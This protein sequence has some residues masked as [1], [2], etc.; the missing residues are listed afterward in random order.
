MPVV[1][2]P[3]VLIHD[4]PFDP[5][6]GY[7][8]PDLL[9]VG[10]PAPE[11]AGFD[12]YWQDRY[13][14]AIAL[15]P[16]FEITETKP[17][18][19]YRRTFLVRIATDGHPELSG[20]IDIPADQPI[21]AGLVMLHG[22]GGRP[23]GP[24]QAVF[25]ENCAV[26]SPGL[27]GLAPSLIDGLSADAMKHVLTGIEDRNTYVL[28]GCIEDVWFATTTLL[29][30]F[31]ECAANLNLIGCS[32][33]GGIGLLALAFDP[34]FR[35]AHFS[36]PTFGNH[37]L[38]ATLPCLGSGEAIRLRYQTDPGILDTLAYFDSAT[39][40]K[41]VRIPVSASPA[42]FD[43]AVPPPGQFAA[44]NALAGPTT[45]FVKKAGHFDHPGTAND[46]L[47]DL[48]WLRQWFA[49]GPNAAVSQTLLSPSLQPQT[50]STPTNDNP[51][52][53]Q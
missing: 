38:R 29:N 48:A 8:L 37:P 21:E 30:A 5:T 32:F 17:H 46:D 24:E 36:V 14:R 34:R 7:A 3:V 39:A 16:R 42:L 9:K 4:L 53:R 41:R 35:M 13:S 44:C 47:A 50:G 45:L 19:P 27:R 2:P 33:G 23:E 51:H 49:A 11:P 43:P 40:A 20:W 6:Y 18:A 28:G 22:Y 26:I 52:P 1:P 15:Q 12:A 31:P 25:I 10:P